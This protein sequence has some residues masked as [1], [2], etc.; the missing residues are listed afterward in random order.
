MMSLTNILDESGMAS[1]P[2]VKWASVT[3]NVT[4]YMYIYRHQKMS[5]LKASQIIL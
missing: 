5:L 3:M 1:I 2:W 4:M